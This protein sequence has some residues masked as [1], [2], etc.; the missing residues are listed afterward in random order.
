MGKV[1][2]GLA[3][4]NLTESIDSETGSVDMRPNG[5]FYAADYKPTRRVSASELKDDPKKITGDLLTRLFESVAP[6][7]KNMFKSGG[8]M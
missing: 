3:L 1:D 5:G 2:L 6:R 4:T 8:W 7:K